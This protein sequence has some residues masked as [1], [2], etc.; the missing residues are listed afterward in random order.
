M[1]QV[2]HDFDNP[3]PSGR[4]AIVHGVMLIVFGIVKL[5]A[6]FFPSL[7]GWLKFGFLAP[8]TWMNYDNAIVLSKLDRMLGIHSIF[9]LNTARL[10]KLGSIAIVEHLK[11][12]GAAV[13]AHWHVSKD[14]VHWQPELNVP[15]KY[16]WMD[17]AYAK[18]EFPI[19]AD[20]DFIQF[21]CDYPH[22]LPYY[23]QCL[24]EAKMKGLEI[25]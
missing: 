13:H 3:Y 10:E 9:G 6:R 11:E 15:K 4:W 14:E 25:R 2:L 23:I 7:E 16:W 8:I 17:Q 22:L 20:M 24:S 12:N 18:G 1:V 19:T 5:F 21:H